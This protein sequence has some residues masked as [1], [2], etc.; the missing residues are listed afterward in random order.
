MGEWVPPERPVYEWA[1]IYDLKKSNIYDDLV[2]ALFESRKHLVCALD[3][4]GWYS[5]DNLLKSIRDLFYI[6]KA[7]S[8][9]DYN[10]FYLA[11]LIRNETAHDSPDFTTKEVDGAITRIK[12]YCDLHYPKGTDSLIVPFWGGHN[13]PEPFWN[14]TFPEKDLLVK[15]NHLVEYHKSALAKQEEINR[16]L[17]SEAITLKDDINNYEKGS[18]KYKADIG[19]LSE[20]LALLAKDRDSLQQK[21]D[22]LS[23][24]S[25]GDSIDKIE[26]IS[27][28]RVRIAELDNEIKFLK[29]E[30]KEKAFL[31]EKESNKAPVRKGAMIP[32]LV[33]I[34]I[35]LTAL[36][37]IF[38]V[39]ALGK[40]SELKK[41]TEELEVSS[42]R[43][44][45]SWPPASV[46]EA[47]DCIPH[48]GVDVDVNECTE[49]CKGLPT[50]EE[51]I[52]CGMAIHALNDPI[53]KLEGVYP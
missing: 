8:P 10:S 27:G 42:E 31:L 48:G 51:K 41:T 52:R 13:R 46:N 17:L 33:T 28:Y 32:V 1:R 53:R 25:M 15:A 3:F 20:R 29:K 23:R 18:I 5:K 14:R 4:N 9:K 26:E 30:N 36:A 24:E 43:L 21:A 34:V 50:P 37:T 12:E 40:S 22:L 35:V 19:N 45:A 39:S 47:A 38:G 49:C 44:K 7:I 16:K 2:V 11:I 6:E